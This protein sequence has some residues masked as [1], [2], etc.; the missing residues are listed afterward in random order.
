MG[1]ERDYR[2]DMLCLL[3]QSE[4]KWIHTLLIGKNNTV[5]IGMI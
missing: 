5:E 1:R 4:Q 3:A 2:A